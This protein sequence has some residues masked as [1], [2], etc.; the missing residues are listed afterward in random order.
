MPENAKDKTVT[1]TS[2]D[3]AVASVT[4]GV[5][6]AHEAGTA[7]IT[8]A[9]SNGKTA[10]C[11][12]T[13][14]A[15]AGS[16][17]LDKEMAELTEG[18]T[19]TITATVLPEN[20]TNKAVAWSSSDENVATV[21]DGVVTAVKAGNA[22][23]TVTTVNG[24][25]ATCTITVKAAKNEFPFE[26]VKEGLW[27]YPYI[28]E[29]YNLGLMTGASDT[30]FKPS[31]SMNRGMVAIVLHR[32]EGEEPVE[33]SKVFPDVKNGQY[34]TTAVLWAKANEIITGYNNG[35]FQ[36]LKEVTREEMAT[37]ICRFAKFKGVDTTS[38]Q[39]IKY[40]EDYKQISTYAK[41]PIRWCVEN[42]VISGKYN[43]TK[44]DPQ[45]LATRA[46]CAKMLSQ[47]YKVIYK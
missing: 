13:V 17:M 5:I 6:T 28:E 42:G 10:S 39:N 37:M 1:W 33:Y 27:Y 26:D 36:P 23:I 4:D 40:F 2:S 44:V 9:T 22:T 12:I 41:E 14:Y 20:A 7:T 35:T 11:E 16:V 3:E 32:M 8:A 29:A 46:E 47:A 19:V 15:E 30:L 31:V 45:G 25:T 38:E 18:E 21:K 34:Y 43:G 24:K